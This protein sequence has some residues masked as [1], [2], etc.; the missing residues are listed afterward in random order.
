MQGRAP[1]MRILRGGAAGALHW[2]RL[3]AAVQSSPSMQIQANWKTHGPHAIKETAP[4]HMPIELREK[5]TSTQT[6]SELMGLGTYVV[7]F[8]IGWARLARDIIVSTI[9]WKHLVHSI[10]A[11][12]GTVSANSSPSN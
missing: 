2:R 12:T 7:V 4:Q 11:R 1:K 8:G 9:L 6:R 10:S 5:S 3:Q